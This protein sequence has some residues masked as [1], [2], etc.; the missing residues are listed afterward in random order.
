MVAQ[1]KTYGEAMDIVDS[2]EFLMN[3][4]ICRDYK[5]RKKNE[6][7]N[8]NFGLPADSVMQLYKL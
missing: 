2:V 7:D 3:K 5:R 8:R 1:G 4:I 6:E